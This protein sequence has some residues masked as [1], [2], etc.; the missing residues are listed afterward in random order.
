[1]VANLK[2]KG[3]DGSGGELSLI[4]IGNGLDHL[5]NLGS[6]YIQGKTIHDRAVN[7]EIIHVMGSMARLADARAGSPVAPPTGPAPDKLYR[8]LVQIGS[9]IQELEDQATRLIGSKDTA[10]QA[11]GN[12]RMKQ[13]QTMFE[14]L[15]NFL[16]AFGKMAESA[17]RS[18]GPHQP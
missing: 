14:A 2:A 17:P 4:E 3:F 6:L 1:M 13:A 9:K 16:D 18:A 5:D 8:Q 7:D 12:A 11:K 15:K 10:D